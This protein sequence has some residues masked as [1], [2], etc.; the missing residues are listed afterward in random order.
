MPSRRAGAGRPRAGSP[1]RRSVGV[2]VRVGRRIGRRAP[3]P[4]GVFDAALNLSLHV[5]R[6]QPVVTAR[7]G[8]QGGHERRGARPVPSAMRRSGKGFDAV[9]PR[10]RRTGGNPR[11][12]A[13]PSCRRRRGR[14][15]RRRGRRRRG[16][17][18][19]RPRPVGRQLR[20]RRANGRDAVPGRMLR[21]VEDARHV[22]LEQGF[23]V[24][25]P[26]EQPRFRMLCV[27]QS[28]DVVHVVYRGV[29]LHPGRGRR[30][31]RRTCGRR[32]E[33][34]RPAAGCGQARSGRESPSRRKSKPA[35]RLPSPGSAGG[36]SARAC[37][38]PPGRPRG[39]AGRCPARAGGTRTAPRTRPRCS[40]SPGSARSSPG[41]RR[42]ATST[43]RVRPQSR[44]RRRRSTGRRAE[45]GRGG[46]SVA[47]RTY[48]PTL[49]G[50]A[51]TSAPL[52][53]VRAA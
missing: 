38:R 47:P 21:Q 19:V 7:F 27:R 3:L 39:S 1:R 22:Q 34:P 28:H 26:F 24:D 37:G 12:S 53:P 11:S 41:R 2:G 18:P 6:R 31:P 30:A 20:G 17:F 46:K 45:R 8:E 13:A 10:P 15:G 51:F 50:V 32:A 36:S 23:G 40:G 42:N 9:R 14:G 29:D 52:R 25:P 48:A 5:L 16:R 4:A 44:R 35:R 33:S 49:N 43:L